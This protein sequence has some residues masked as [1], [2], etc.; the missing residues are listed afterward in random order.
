V[1]INQSDLS[2]KLRKAA[3]NQAVAELAL[4]KQ[5]LGHGNKRLAKNKDYEATASLQQFGVI[6]SKDALQQRIV[7]AFNSSMPDVSKVINVFTSPSTA[8]NIIKFQYLLSGSHKK[9]L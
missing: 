2:K 6:I 7:G 5:S 8:F 9:F 4:A 1:S 3:I